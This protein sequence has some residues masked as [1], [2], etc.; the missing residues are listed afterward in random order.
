VLAQH[1]QNDNL[2]PVSKMLRTVCLSCHG[3]A[4]SIDALA[5]RELTRRNYK[6]RPSRHVESMDMV[7]AKR[8]NSP[9][10][11]GSGVPTE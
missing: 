2:R 6:G 8:R 4:F 7:E 10:P 9:Q 11:A 1:N 3:L 5:D